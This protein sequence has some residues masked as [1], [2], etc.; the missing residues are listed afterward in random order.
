MVTCTMFRFMI[1]VGATIAAFGLL[2]HLQGRGMVGPE[3]SF[4][5]NSPDW[6]GYGI[7][8]LAAGAT[9]SGAGVLLWLR[10]R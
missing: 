6:W 10:A 1:P 3:A 5:Y 9:V 2:F 7:W 4:M 8:I